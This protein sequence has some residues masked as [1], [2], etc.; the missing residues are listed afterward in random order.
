MM[1]FHIHPEAPVVYS[2]EYLIRSYHVD[3][4]RRLTIQKLC[5]FF[6]DIAGNHTVACGVGWEVMQ[7][8]QMFWV[9]SRLKISIH[10]FPEWRD[11]IVIRTWSNGL[12][13]L[14]A[15]RHFQ[16]H[17]ESGQEL[18]RAVS[19]WLMVN[20]STRRL[21]RPEGYMENFP[22]NRERLFD[23]LPDKIEGLKGP[24]SFEPARVSFTE[25]DMNQH[26]NNVSYIDRIMNCYDPDFLADQQIETFEINFLKEAI[27]GE[28]IVVQQ[29]QTG[30]GTFLHNIV[31][32]ESGKEMVRTHTVWKTKGPDQI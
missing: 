4:Y 12:D 18:V 8:A 30:P 19:M 6:Q 5:S 28:S 26:M 2:E 15:V 7:E 22:L 9:L 1:K 27:P 13:G 3:R 14:M 16:V 29:E 24:I 11:R 32:H 31:Q 20:T 10:K 21:V 25:T 17:D 23:E